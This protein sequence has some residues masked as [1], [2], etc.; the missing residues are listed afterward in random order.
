[1][2]L[3][4]RWVQTAVLALFPLGL[5]A[6]HPAKSD[7]AAPPMFSDDHGVLTVPATSPLR[8]HIAVQSVGQAGAGAA[9]DLP[10]AVEADPARVVSIV[11][12]AA[13]RVLALKVG[14]G[15]HVRRGQVLLILASGDFAQAR[16]DAQKADD[17]ADLAKKALDRAHGVLALGGAATKDL[18]TAQ[19]S[20]N[21]ALAEQIRARAKLASL[22]SS[23][24]GR[25][26][27]LIVAAP[28]SGVVT[29]LA[30]A[31]G[32]QVNDAAA[33]LMT[34]T[35]L[36]RVFVTANVAE[37][38]IGKVTPG[39]AASVSLTADPQ[40][41]LSGRISE[42]SP[43]LDADTRRQKVRIAL[44]NG[45]GRLLPN[46][47]ATVRLP[48]PSSGGV[49]VSQSAL[50]MNN[51]ALSVLVEVRPWVF[52]RRAVK[53]GDETNTAAQVL[54]GLSAGDRV[55]VRGGVLLDD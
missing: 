25:S 52:M 42:V 26:R 4:S 6:C 39:A 44:A 8:T 1:M 22:E 13:G 38:D 49:Y 30:V 53:I 20:Y 40:H 5:I 21:Q 54:S 12:P 23:A 41:P 48:A 18:E 15:Q 51:D 11:A 36:D 27:Q 35:N 14:L 47:Y 19:S 46:M 29:T 17:A 16:A 34:V 45:N 9:L 50:I 43:S 28:Q 2:Q 55:V 10:A 7:D 37:G 33:V 24:N 3:K 32:A 31:A